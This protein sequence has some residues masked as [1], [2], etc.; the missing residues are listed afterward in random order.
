[1]APV[2]RPQKRGRSLGAA[3]CVGL[4]CCATASAREGV[5]YRANRAGFLP[6]AHRLGTSSTFRKDGWV[7]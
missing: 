2:D 7:I 5:S 3:C 1:M 6:V 4:L